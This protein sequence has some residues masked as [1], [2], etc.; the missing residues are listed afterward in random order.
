MRKQR[1]IGKMGVMGV[2]GVMG[3]LCRGGFH[4]YL[5]GYTQM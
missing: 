1:E 2:I 4:N 3:K 5:F